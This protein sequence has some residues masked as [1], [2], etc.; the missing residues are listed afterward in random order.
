MLGL[1]SVLSGGAFIGTGA[2]STVSVL[3]NA[4]G[5][6][7]GTGMLLGPNL[8]SIDGLAIAVNNAAAGTTNI[9]NSGTITSTGLSVG[10]I[11]QAD[12]P[13]VGV[14]GGSQVNMANSSTGIVNGRVAFETSAAGNTFT[15]AGAIVGSVAMGAAPTRSRR[16]PV[17]RCR[18]VTV[19]RSATV[20]VG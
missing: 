9:V 12:T 3:N 17:L 5:I 20:S 14:Y 7:R 2:T 4:S 18:S 16:S 13:V 1:V 8:T 10:G 19:F 6:M 15:N 11:T